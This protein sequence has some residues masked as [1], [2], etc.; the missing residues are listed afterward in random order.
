[1]FSWNHNK[2]FM[3]LTKFKISNKFKKKFQKKLGRSSTGK[4]LVRHR[5][6]GHREKKIY[7]DWNS[8]NLYDYFCINFF[9]LA[10]KKFL[11]GKYN[12][13]KDNKLYQTYKPATFSIVDKKKM[14]F[15]SNKLNYKTYLFF[16]S[17]GDSISQISNING[18]KINPVFVKSAGTSAQ[19]I[20]KDKF[21]KNYYLIKLP[22]TKHYYIHKNNTAFKGEVPI[23]KNRSKNLS[24]AGESRYLGRRPKV[25]GVAMNPIDH[26]H[27]GGEGKTSGGRP[28]VSLWGKLTK[29]VKTRKKKKSN[30]FFYEK[31]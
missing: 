14:S 5:E 12:F 23:N 2:A 28:S 17:V 13:W 6:K 11:I 30:K 29:G 21:L 1:M 10:K 8:Y 22:S 4:I 24:K 26:P 20:Q 7:M 9:P 16:L 25:R 31:I 18:L 3:Q 15:L 27:G 19:L